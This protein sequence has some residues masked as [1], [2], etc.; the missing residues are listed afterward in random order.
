MSHL[1]NIGAKK[2]ILTVTYKNL[3]T[4]TIKKRLKLEQKVNSIKMTNGIYD[5]FIFP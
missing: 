4:L 2:I 3:M 5:H 1:R